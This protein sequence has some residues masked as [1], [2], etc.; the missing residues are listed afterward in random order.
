M[1]LFK[2]LHEQLPALS[3]AF[4]LST[5]TMDEVHALYFWAVWLSTAQERNGLTN[6]SLTAYME[7]FMEGPSDI[8]MVV[9]PIPSVYGAPPIGVPPADAQ[10]FVKALRITMM[11]KK[12]VWT[13]AIGELLKFLGAPINFV[14]ANFIP[15]A[16]GKASIGNIAVHANT[17]FVKT[18]NLYARITGTSLWIFVRTFNGA[19]YDYHRTPVTPNMPESVDMMVKGVINNEEIGHPSPTFSVLYQPQQTPPPIP[20]V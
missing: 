14:P 8:S 10:G 17:K 6:V 11:K 7:A 9:L 18:F 20:V 12:G 1:L 16:D 13:D 4:G 2:T 19:H 15:A 3:A 5:P